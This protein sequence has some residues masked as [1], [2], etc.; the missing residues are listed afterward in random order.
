MM[1]FVLNEDNLGITKVDDVDLSNSDA[2]KKKGGN[3]NI[4]HTEETKK[5]MSD[6]QKARYDLI[7][8]YVRK[9]MQSQ[10]SDAERMRK[11]T[12]TLAEY[13]RTNNNILT[14]Y[15]Q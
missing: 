13:R 7:R 6:K 14:D 4:P 12:E 9:G 8:Q 5:L 11:N 3:H 15:C 10:L 1:Y 2:Q